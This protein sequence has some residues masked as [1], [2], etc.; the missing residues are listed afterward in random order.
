MVNQTLISFKIDTKLLG[1]LNKI[2]VDHHVKRNRF[3][4]DA[5]VELMIAYTCNMST[6]Q[7]R[8]HLFE[9]FFPVSQNV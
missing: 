2:C 5:I 7:F 9:A 3:I 6:S 1:R 4:N 8:C